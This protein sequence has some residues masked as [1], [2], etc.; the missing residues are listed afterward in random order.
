M[1][2]AMFAASAKA[3]TTIAIIADRL[4]SCHETVSDSL[5]FRCDFALLDATTAMIR[6]AELKNTPPMSNETIAIICAM[7]TSRLVEAKSA[8]STDGEPCGGNNGVLFV[9]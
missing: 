2:A 4:S 8:M 5:S 3:D 7:V 6:A 9:S 1:S